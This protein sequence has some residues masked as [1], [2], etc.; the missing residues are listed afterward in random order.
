MIVPRIISAALLV[1]ALLRGIRIAEVRCLMPV[2]RN[3]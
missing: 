2:Q 1:A 3:L